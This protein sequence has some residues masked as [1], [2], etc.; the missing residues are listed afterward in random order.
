[1]AFHNEQHH[2]EQGHGS[3]SG[4]KAPR[5]EPAVPDSPT[6][7][8]LVW[9]SW[10]GTGA[11]ALTAVPA[12]V[13]PGLFV[14]V[15]VIVSLVLF[16]VGV[17]AFAWA[18]LVAIGRSRTDLLGMGGLFFLAGSAPRSVQRNL[19]GSFIIEVVLALATASARPFTPVAF[20]ILAPMYGLGVM[21]LWGAKFGTFP[22]RPPDPPRPGRRRTGAT[23]EPS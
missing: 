9:V 23:S 4:P 2:N 7:T 11:L 6:A 18:Y 21:G 1:V 15:A 17:V 20:A 10:L 12:A 19:V 3:G 13:A 14:G 8:R 5:I 16:T 22:L